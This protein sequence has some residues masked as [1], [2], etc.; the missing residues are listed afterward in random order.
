VCGGRRGLITSVPRNFVFILSLYVCSLKIGFLT[1]LADLI[2]MT[3][4]L[5]FS[6]PSTLAQSV[7]T[8][9][10][11]YMA[12]LIGVLLLSSLKRFKAAGIELEPNPFVMTVKMMLFV[13]YG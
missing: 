5:A 9:V 4:I 10:T 11:F 1:I 12:I 8:A 3:V 2:I 13:C 6:Y 7:V